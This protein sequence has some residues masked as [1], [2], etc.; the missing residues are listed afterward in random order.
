MT[1]II[2]KLWKEP[3]RSSTDEWIHTHTHTHTQT[4]ILFSHNKNEILPSETTEIELQT[5]MP[6]KIKSEKDKYHMISLIRGTE[7]TKQ[8]SKGGEKG[9]RGEPRNRALRRGDKLMVIRGEVG[10]SMGEMTDGD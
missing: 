8:T 3:K 1:Y 10:G 6:S 5:I 7:E 4:G 9:E 2:A